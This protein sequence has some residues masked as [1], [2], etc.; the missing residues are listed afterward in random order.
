M[1]VMLLLARGKSVIGNRIENKVLQKEA[2][3]TVIDASLAGAI[4]IGL[5][6]NA[7]LGWWWP[8]IAASFAL[9]YYGIKEG[10]QAFRD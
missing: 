8:D 6:L 3:V 9:V 2:K 1:V 5:V 10:V 7:T 4:L